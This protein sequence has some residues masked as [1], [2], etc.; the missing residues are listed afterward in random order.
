MLTGTEGVGKSTLAAYLCA[1]HGYTEVTFAGPLREAAVALWNDLGTVIPLPAIT[2]ADTMD[3]ATKETPLCRMDGTPL[4]LK[5]KPLT[6]RVILQWFGT[7]IVRTHVSEQVWVDAALAKMASIDKVV[8][9]D[10]RFQN[11]Q[12]R[13]QQYGAAST[14]A[15]PPCRVTTARIVHADP[16]AAAA[17]AAKSKAASAHASAVGWMALHADVVLENP[18]DAATR[19]DWL[20]TAAGVLLGA[21]DS[22]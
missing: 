22:Q 6:P 15:G 1:V 10:L 18:M 17:A 13:V 9:S 20:H 11:E 19:D 7:D 14:A 2:V 3:P 5:S 8:V 21:N 16:A 4:T 12:Q